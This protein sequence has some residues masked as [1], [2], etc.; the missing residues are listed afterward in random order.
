MI[1]LTTSV[2]I[3]KTEY[4]LENKI[5]PDKFPQKK[6]RCAASATQKGNEYLFNK[7]LPSSDLYQNYQKHIWNKINSTRPEFNPMHFRTNERHASWSQFMNSW[8][9]LVWPCVNIYFAI[10][11]KS[12]G[13][14]FSFF[15][16]FVWWKWRAKLLKSLHPYQFKIFRVLWT[17][18][19]SNTER[20]IRPGANPVHDKH[21]LT[22]NYRHSRIEWLAWQG[23]SK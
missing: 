20:C 8:I 6:A 5:N 1:L 19:F 23:A 18:F 12:L 3:T 9:R 13:S 22:E 16:P 10:T 2:E 4:P 7:E 14:V 11:A 17:N 15:L 21:W